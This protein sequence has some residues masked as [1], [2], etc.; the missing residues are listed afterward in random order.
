M[1]NC[2]YCGRWFKTKRGLKQHITKVHTDSFGTIDPMTINPFN[3]TKNKRR[4]RSRRKDSD[5][6]GLFGL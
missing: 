6:L 4:K 2:P 3:T 1:P 5:V